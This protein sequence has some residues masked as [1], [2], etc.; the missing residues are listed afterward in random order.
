[1]E[2]FSVFTSELDN[3]EIHSMLLYALLAFFLGEE[4]QFEMS[5]K[6]RNAKD[7]TILSEKP[8]YHIK[9]TEEKPFT[10]SCVTDPSVFNKVSKIVKDCL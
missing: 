1:M 6:G 8:D 2:F 9:V 7:Y 3:N 10:V 5:A 4:V